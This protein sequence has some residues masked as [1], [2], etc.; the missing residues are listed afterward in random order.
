MVGGVVRPEGAKAP[1]PEQRPGFSDGERISSS[2]W[3]HVFLRPA[4]KITFEVFLAF[5]RA[6]FVYPLKEHSELCD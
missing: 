6:G 1:S 2:S 5:S 3:W 4:L